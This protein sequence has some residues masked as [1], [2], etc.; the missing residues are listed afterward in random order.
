M[1]PKLKKIQIRTI[2][3]NCSNLILIAMK[4]PHIKF[5]EIYDKNTSIFIILD[6]LSNCDCVGLRINVQGF[7]YVQ[8]CETIIT[9]FTKH[10]TIR[11]IL[12]YIIKLKHTKK[13]F[14]LCL[15]LNELSIEEDID[16]NSEFNY[17]FLGNLI[18]PSMLET[19]YINSFDINIMNLT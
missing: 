13:I 18:F 19:V 6:I 8:D 3:E 11:C 15:N 1:S 14:N 10:I 5:I 9:I 17:L 12:P 4:K 2:V 16:G 7:N